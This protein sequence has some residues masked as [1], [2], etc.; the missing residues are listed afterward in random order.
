LGIIFTEFTPRRGRTPDLKNHLGHTNSELGSR[1]HVMLL[2]SH[3][4]KKRLSYFCQL[5]FQFVDNLLEIGPKRNLRDC[6]DIHTSTR[7]FRDPDVELA[8]RFTLLGVVF[9]E[10]SAPAFLALMRRAGNSFR[11]GKHMCK[12]NRRV[13]ARIVPSVSAA[14]D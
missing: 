2:I 10:V 1:G 9:A 3:F 7:A 5:L 8:K 12:F 14:V 6:R 11:N 13:P 4:R